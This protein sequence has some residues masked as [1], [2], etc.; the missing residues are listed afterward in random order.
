MRKQPLFWRQSPPP[1]GS[2]HC[3][4]SSFGMSSFGMSS[5]G[6]SSFGL[7]SRQNCLTS[8]ANGA[9]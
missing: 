6:M 4:M 5:F 1:V 7:S 3:R 9:P 2:A 8:P